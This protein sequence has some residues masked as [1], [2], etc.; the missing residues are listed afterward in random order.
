MLGRCFDRGATLTITTQAPGFIR[1]HRLLIV[2]VCIV[3]LFLLAEGTVR[4]VADRLPQPEH[5]HDPAVEIKFEQMEEI[6]AEGETREVVFAG[7]SM[8]NN[9]ANPNQFTELTGITSFNSAFPAANPFVTER[10]VIEE[11]VP[12]LR[13]KAV[14]YDVTSLGLNGA[15][16]DSNSFPNYNKSWQMRRGW[17]ADLERWAADHSDLVYFRPV[18]QNPAEYGDIVRG[19]KGEDTTSADDLFARN[20]RYGDNGAKNL[21]VEQLTQDNNQWLAQTAFKAW[22]IDNAE[23]RAGLDALARQVDELEAMGIDVFFVEMPVQQGFIELHPRGIVDYDE[24]MAVFEDFAADHGVTWIDLP[25]DYSSPELFHDLNHL[26]QP[27]ADQFTHDL[28]GYFET[29]GV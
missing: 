21:I 9:A 5:F 16:P 8:M 6:H 23:S 26:A 28:A 1:R 20:R 10:W 27:G 11:V 15:V 4:I 18:L 2:T 13:P 7:S 12:R 24:A 14:V 25:S 22:D 29:H 19:L 3:A 17:L